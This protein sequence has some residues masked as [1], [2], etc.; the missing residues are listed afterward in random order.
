MNVLQK[1]E[2]GSTRLPRVRKRRERDE[3]EDDDETP[4]VDSFMC[5]AN[6]RKLGF[7]RFGGH[8]DADVDVRKQPWKQE[9]S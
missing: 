8:D 4:G 3:D 6:A 5:T 2:K 7:S 1:Q 9:D